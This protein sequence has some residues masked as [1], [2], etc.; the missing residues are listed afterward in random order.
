MWY[1][2]PLPAGEVLVAY[3]ETDDFASAL[4]RFSQSRDAFDMW[5]KGRFADVTGVD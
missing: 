3:M 4:N 2:A 1:L 5:F